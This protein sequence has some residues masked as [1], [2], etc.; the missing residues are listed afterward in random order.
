MDAAAGSGVHGRRTGSAETSFSSRPR[1]AI[2][3]PSHGNAAATPTIAQTPME[4]RHPWA[5]ATGT[6]S[7]GG[8]MVLIWSAQM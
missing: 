8:I 7:S 6:A 3:T 5:S 2:T 1:R 4:S